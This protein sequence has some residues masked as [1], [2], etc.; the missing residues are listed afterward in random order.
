MLFSYPVALVLALVAC[1][2]VW[3][4]SPPSPTTGRAY[5]QGALP[6]TVVDHTGQPVTVN[7]V[8]RIV[9]LNGDVTETVVALGLADHLVGVDASSTFPESLASLPRVGYQR[10]L[11]AEGVLSLS[12]TV[13]VG[14][15]SAG[16][17]AVLEQLRSAGVPVVI[18]S[19]PPTLGAPAVKLRTLGT[20]LGVPEQGEALAADL[21]REIE[22]VRA[23]AGQ[24]NERPRVLFLYVRGA[25]GTQLAAGSETG[26]GIMIEAAGGLNAGA[27][28]GLVGYQPLTPEAVVAA[29]PD[30]LLLLSAGLESVGGVDGL[31]QIGGLL[32]TPAGLQ[33]RVVAMDDLYLLGMGPRTAAA[34]RD[35]Q[36]ALHPE[37][38]AASR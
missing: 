17:A 21:E 1:A 15:E 6:V 9:S 31:L 19:D 20:A 33:R 18:A 30:V 27:E 22:A 28:A 34:L 36:D 3:A 32:Q 35:L 37:L 11:S 29:N 8:E 7:S 4:S 10:T 2:S 12:P 38:R 5:A 16:P 26:A 13:V 23:R 14:D 24:V 25:S